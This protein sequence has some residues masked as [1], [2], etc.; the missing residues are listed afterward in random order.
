MRLILRD[1][2]LSGEPRVG[3][4][5]RGLRHARV[6]NIVLENVHASSGHA[7]NVSDIQ[8]PSGHPLVH[9]LR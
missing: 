7:S 6:Q 9:D 3:R 4:H 2:S 1:Y 5:S 8:Q